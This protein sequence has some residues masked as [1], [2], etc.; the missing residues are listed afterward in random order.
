[1]DLSKIRI[2]EIKDRENIPQPD[3][4]EGLLTE[5]CSFVEDCRPGSFEAIQAHIIQLG[6]Q[7]KND[8]QIAWAVGRAVLDEARERARNASNARLQAAGLDP[9]GEMTEEEVDKWLDIEAEGEDRENEIFLSSFVGLAEKQMIRR[10]FEIVENDPQTRAAFAQNREA[11][12]HLR[13]NYIRHP[14]ICDRV[15]SLS[16]SLR[17]EA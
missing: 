5:I 9:A 8:S 17:A 1:M 11:F 12:D 2:Y 16:F 4:P 10:A 13:N 7:G 14:K 3:S 15:R 6:E